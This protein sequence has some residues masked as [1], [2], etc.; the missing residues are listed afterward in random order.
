MT[1]IWGHWWI[2]IPLKVLQYLSLS[3]KISSVAKL[4]EKPCKDIKGRQIIFGCIHFTCCCALCYQFL[5]K[6]SVRKVLEG[7]ILKVELS[8]HLENIEMVASWISTFNAWTILSSLKTDSKFQKQCEISMSYVLNELIIHEI[9]NL[10]FFVLLV[11]FPESELTETF[12]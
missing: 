11:K 10:I 4:H 9:L 2:R 7:R 6:M 12:F 1:F 8:C 3:I 5:K